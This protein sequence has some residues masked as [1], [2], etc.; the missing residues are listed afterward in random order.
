VNEPAALQRAHDQ[1]DWR[2]H[3]ADALESKV[4]R[5]G[6]ALRYLEDVH[7][8]FEADDDRSAATELRSTGGLLRERAAGYSDRAR[9]LRSAH[10]DEPRP[11]LP[12]ALTTRR[13]G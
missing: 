1:H 11:E 3:E 5:I 13:A 7:A 9:A 12:R 10:R 8:I 4:I 2:L 6:E